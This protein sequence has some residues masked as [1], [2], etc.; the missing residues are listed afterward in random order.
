MTL[1]IFRT[2]PLRR[3]ERAM[4]ARAA[5]IFRRRCRQDVYA[6]FFAMY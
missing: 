1:I 5:L 6:L 2:M 3:Q 4:R